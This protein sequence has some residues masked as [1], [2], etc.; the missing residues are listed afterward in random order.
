MC[1]KT[2]HDLDA[3]HYFIILL[4]IIILTD[5]VIF[6]NIIFLRQILGFLCF[7]IIPGILILHI[8]KVN[9]I[10]FLKKVVLSIG[11]SIAFLMF[12]GLFVSGL[13]PLVSKPLS[14]FPLLISFNILLVILAF[15]AYKR[16]KDDFDIKDVFNFKLDLKDKMIFPLLFPILFP[17]MAAFG[18]YLMNTQGNN[19]ILLVMLF[20]IPAYVVAVV[21]LRNKIPESTYPIAILMIGMSLSLMYGLRSNCMSSTD[22]SIEYY[23]FQLTLSNFNWD[24]SEYYNDL[25]ACLSVTILPTLYK[26]FLGMDDA[27]IYKILYN[28]ICS[29]IPLCTYLLFK[30]YVNKHCALLSSFFFMAQYPFISILGWIAFRQII[31]LIFFALAILVLFEDKID[32]LN[33]KLLFIIFIICIIVSHYSTAYVFFIMIFLYWLVTNLKSIRPKIT[34]IKPRKIKSK[35]ITAITIVLFFVLIFFW[36]SQITVAPFNNITLF[37]KNNLMNLAHLSVE[38][39]KHEESIL[40]IGEDQVADRINF[41]IH[42]I[43]FAFIAAGVFSLIK[44][45]MGF[46]REYL[47]MIFLSFG[48][49]VLL[50]AASLFIVGYGASRVYQQLL[51]FL[52]PA[53]VIGGE[54]ISKFI[55]RF[56]PKLNI[57]LVF[58]LIVLIAQF[59][60]STYI[61]YQICGVHHS[62][63]LNSDG[64]RYE[65]YYIHDKDFN[66]ANWIYEHNT[67]NLY[68]WGDYPGRYIYGQFDMQHIKLLNP[69]FETRT[70]YV[71]LRTVN[72]I[73]GHIYP[74]YGTN[75]N[76]STYSHLFI[77]KNKIYA[78]GGSE[79]YK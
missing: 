76:I 25:N 20:L 55:P 56:N 28:L 61:V 74:I 73:K 14:L 48:I 26:V 43:S 70:D 65:N 33:K 18:T 52:A 9:R 17:F 32:I 35:N 57:S 15:T 37:M 47:W 22:S 5:L 16:N 77:N 68:V 54:T 36:H 34:E 64:P 29:I 11:L 30:K 67:E 44:N 60:S 10:E 8:L 1:K 69:K 2:L 24:V 40:P 6:L 75:E 45:H 59:F 39:L 78:N 72:T 63:V 71:Y 13:Y 53:F 23:T 4:L 19:I 49:L 12:V 46:E 58:I 42:Y 27:Y 7:T 3:E 31:A 66:G 50:S 62:E 51:V 41:L 21:Y 38:G 79:V